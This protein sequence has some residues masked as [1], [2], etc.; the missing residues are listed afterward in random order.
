MLRLCIKTTGQYF[1]VH[2]ILRQSTEIH[3]LEKKMIE[4]DISRYA[5]LNSPV[6]EANPN[7]A[8]DQCHDLDI[9]LSRYF[10]FL[11]KK[12]RRVAE[13]G[14]NS[15]VCSGGLQQ[16]LIRQSEKQKQLR[17]DQTEHNQQ[18]SAFECLPI[19][20]RLHIFSY[21]TA[22]ELCNVSRV[23]WSWYNLTE[24]NL[25]WSELLARDIHKWSTIG[26]CSNPA[27]YREVDS[28]LSNK[29]IY[30]RCSP[31]IKMLQNQQNYVFNNISSLLKYF[32]PKKT[33]LFVMFGP[34]LETDTSG[35][36]RGIIEGPEFEKT[37]MFPGKFDGVGGGFTLRNSE[38]CQFHLSVMYSAS[39]KEREAANRVRDQSH[40]WM[41]ESKSENGESK[42]EVLPAVQ[43]FCKTVDGFIYVVDASSDTP[44]V[45]TGIHELQA[46]VSERWSATYVP[47]LVLAAA[48]R[49]DT[50]R[51]SCFEV[52][53]R[54]KLSQLSRPWQVQNCDTATKEGIPSG[55]KWLAEQS[56]RKY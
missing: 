28:E 56:R 27:I 38:G 7:L 29:E 50:P 1:C 21:L 5:G 15:A 42:Y 9:R 37:G 49:S 53:E 55:L 44:S 24:D 25:L 11:M 33:P 45:E 30:L 43:D 6:F 34:G 31:E 41:Q 39:K 40:K 23:C 26:H 36:V 32:L 13:M 8:T 48:K 18:Q 4:T 19:D 2:C 52:V 14:E 35:I 46:M 54:L 20:V 22:K 3:W 12:Y 47:V 51:L 16:Y 17:D 10:K